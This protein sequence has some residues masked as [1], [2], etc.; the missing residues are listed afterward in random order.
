MVFP[1]HHVRFIAVNDGADSEKGENEFNPFRNILNEW[2]ARD[3]SKKVRVIKQAKGMEGKPTAYHV[4]Y[5]Y[6][7][8]LD[9]KYQWIVDEETWNIAQRL[10]KTIRRPDSLGEANPLTGLLFCADCGAKMYNERDRG[11]NG[12]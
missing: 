9:D 2:F 5:G 6:L 10:S 12:K 3:T 11:K 8:N 7:K 1:E 4:V